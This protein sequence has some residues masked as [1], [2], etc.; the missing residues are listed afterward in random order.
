MRGGFMSPSLLNAET[1]TPIVTDR[2][3]DGTWFFHSKP[4]VLGRFS[5][6]GQNEG[7]GPI[8]KYFDRIR[9]DSRCGANTFE[10]AECEMFIEAIDGAIAHAGLNETDIDLLV[11]GDLL[12]QLVSVNFAARCY[13]L[14]FFGIY[15]ACATSCES[16]AMSAAFV[17]AG[18]CNRVACCTGSHFASAERQYRGPLELGAQRAPYSQNTVTGCGCCVIGKQTQGA[19][20]TSATIGR[21]IDY[22]IVDLTNMGA[23][24]APAAR[25]TLIRHFANTGTTPSD[26]DRVI[27]GDLGKLG[28]DILRQLMLE[29]GIELPNYIDCGH[30]MY[31]HEQ[32]MSQGGS[33]AGCSMSVLNAY[34]IPMLET[35]E[36]KKILLCATG[37][38]MSPIVNQQGESIPCIAHAIVLEA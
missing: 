12:N 11:G 33:G 15:N 1:P 26:Y 19:K 17:D 22:G 14:P 31:S 6:A 7:K 37:A 23:A 20:I 5:I 21:V 27:T 2:S 9:K 34:F 16:L 38:L 24:M 29:E 13:N 25:D 3:K 30:M 4:T 10:K 35:G 36:F 8:G 32:H 28:E 18:L